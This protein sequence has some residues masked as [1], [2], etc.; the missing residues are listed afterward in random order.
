MLSAKIASL[1]TFD[2]RN[3]ILQLF[4]DNYHVNTKV[5]QQKRKVDRINHC[6]EVKKKI[7][8]NVRRRRES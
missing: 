7:F 3:K 6:N 1:Y 2:E 8:Y 4:N 5:R